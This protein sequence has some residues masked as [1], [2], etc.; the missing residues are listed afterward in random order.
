MQRSARSQRRSWRHVNK[1]K[2][3]GCWR[4]KVTPARLR[5]GSKH[6][7]ALCGTSQQHLH[8]RE[9]TLITTQDFAT[10]LVLEYDRP[11]GRSGD[12]S[13]EHRN[14]RLAL[15]RCGTPGRG[16]RAVF[17]VAAMALYLA[18]GEYFSI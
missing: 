13:V 18:M 4:R 7:T 1:R 6:Y 2:R 17:L 10:H 5:R 14:M 8:T 11:K 15:D 3:A 16:L 12:D 9:H